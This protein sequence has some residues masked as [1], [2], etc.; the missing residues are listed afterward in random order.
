MDSNTNA[1]L[2]SP[3]TSGGSGSK[4]IVHANS[5]DTTRKRTCPVDRIAFD[6]ALSSNKR[7]KDEVTA[8]H[9]QTEPT[10]IM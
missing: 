8:E 5:N 7:N 3:T 2:V 6:D 1:K 10:K 4:P 9:S